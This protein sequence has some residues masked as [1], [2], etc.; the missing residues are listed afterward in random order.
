MTFSFPMEHIFIKM[1]GV[2]KVHN[3][4]EYDSDDIAKV[5]CKLAGFDEDGKEFTDCEQAIYDLKCTKENP[6]NSDFYRT[7][8]D[9]L[10]I[11]T[12]NYIYS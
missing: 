2:H 10:Q 8:W 9:V 3:I 1:K 11:L 7:L 6:Y 4:Y 5:L 12:D